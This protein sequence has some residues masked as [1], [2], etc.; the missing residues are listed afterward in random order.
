M[1]VRAVETAGAERHGVTELTLGCHASLPRAEPHTSPALALSEIPR[2]VHVALRVRSASPPGT[3][4]R[5]VQSIF[6]RQRAPE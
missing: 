2:P 1:L 3:P 6:Y 4:L 5:D